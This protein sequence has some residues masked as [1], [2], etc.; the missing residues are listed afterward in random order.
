MNSIRRE[1]LASQVVAVIQATFE[2][3]TIQDLELVLESAKYQARA[4][5]S[6]KPE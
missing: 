2:R 5:C 3:P 6:Q 4:I 1:E